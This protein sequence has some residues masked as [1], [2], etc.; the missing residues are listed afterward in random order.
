[1]SLILAI[2]PDHRQAAQLADLIRGRLKADLVHA[3]TTEGA[4]VA[5]AGIGDRVPDLVLVPSLLSAQEDAAIAG[6][7][8]VIAAAANVRMLTIPMLADPEQPPQQRG[9]FAKLRGRKTQ[10]TP[11]G[12]DPAVFAEQIASYL[13]EAAAERRAAQEADADLVAPAAIP[14][15]PKA[16]P[17][18]AAT[19]RVA[20]PIVDEIPAPVVE[21]VLEAPT[22]TVSIRFAP[23]VIGPAP[24]PASN[25]DRHVSVVRKAPVQ[26]DTPLVLGESSGAA[27]PEEPRSPWLSA[28]AAPVIEPESAVR[29][30]GAEATFVEETIEV[31]QAIEEPI[32]AA[33]EDTIPIE[34]V[35]QTW[36]AS[37][38]S[39]PIASTV[40][41][42]DAPHS[43]ATDD[44]IGET[45]DRAIADPV[46]STLGDLAQLPP[47]IASEA[48][49]RGAAED[50][51]QVLAIEEVLQALALEEAE[52]AGPVDAPAP[53]VAAV[54][55]AP[56][57]VAIP[58]EPS[59]PESPAEEKPTNERARGA[60]RRR[61]AR[62]AAAE[63]DD[64]FDI[65]A[66]LAPLL[67][68][69]AAKRSAPATVA[70]SPVAATADHTPAIAAPIEVSAALVI[71]E[72]PAMPVAEVETNDP[73]P[74]PNVA[75][76]PVVPAVPVEQAE[77]IDRPPLEQIAAVFAP[78]EPP[79]LAPRSFGLTANEPAPTALP[80]TEFVA[81]ELPPAQWAAPEMAATAST[82]T[83][84]ASTEPAQVETTLDVPMA[85]VPAASVSAPVELRTI[86]PPPVQVSW[87]EP[88]PVMPAP[89]EPAPMAAMTSDYAPAPIGGAAEADIDPMFFADD[90]HEGVSD[91][92]PHDRP[93]W[94]ELIESLRKDIERLKADRAQPAEAA[95]PPPVSTIVSEPP[96]P[97][98]LGRVLSIAA[99]RPAT[100][101]PAAPAEKL[102]TLT[103]RVKTPKPVQDQWG[104]FDPEQCGFAA[105]RA[106]LDEISSRE[107][108][109][110]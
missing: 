20:A 102:S 107:E 32:P 23:L 31:P 60:R 51:S 87:V 15:A 9:V 75:I 73:V 30:Q 33:I 24:R 67:S 53:S 10:T 71:S 50:E 83:E 101:A 19:P 86:E 64:R 110:V 2:E 37:V 72:P 106:K 78:I 55:D 47:V 12:C 96:T 90:V 42:A 1:M 57:V 100:P 35:E 58:E 103:P 74:A 27:L 25:F 62:R 59:A 80:A 7:L 98:R 17:P 49:S 46:E 104:L 56:V 36:A 109:S 3:H 34:E 92:S 48:L 44:A 54:D 28:P 39:E 77:P 26:A 91:P 5:L 61:K 84:F 85:S 63:S 70:P 94:V 89:I 69:I 13:A 99:A 76:D 11:G 8:R 21:P 65:D 43:D 66:L 52:P 108:V 45:I 68:E 97:P 88:T 38:I 18:V 22:E 41:V 6:A 14:A 16:E 79:S 40:L 93:A 95:A 82:S 105:L 4:L 29:E 81:T